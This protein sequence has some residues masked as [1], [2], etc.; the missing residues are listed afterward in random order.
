MNNLKE[1]LLKISIVISY[2]FIIIVLIIA[3]LS[4]S[5]TMAILIFT[6]LFTITY[7][8]IDRRKLYKVEKIQ[9]KIIKLENDKNNLASD[10]VGLEKNKNELNTEVK[11]LKSEINNLDKDKEENKKTLN[12]EVIDIENS[13]KDLEAKKESIKENFRK[14]ALEGYLEKLKIEYSSELKKDNEELENKSITLKNEYKNL[15]TDYENLKQEYDELNSHSYGIVPTDFQFEK[16]ETYKMKLDNIHLKEKE[17]IAR[18]NKKVKNGRKISILYDN[19]E[20]LSFLYFNM[21]CDY[22]LSKLN[23]NNYPTRIK[24][25]EKLHSTIFKVTEY[26]VDIPTQYKELKLEELETAY[27][28][29][30][31]KEREKEILREQREQEKDDLKAQKEIKEKHDKIDKEI[32]T[33]SLVKEKIEEKI[34]LAANEEIEALKLEL[35]KL[36]EKIS[37]FENEKSDLDYR[38]KNTGAGYVY[39]ISNIGSFGE[40]VYKIGVTRRLDPYQRIQEL[41]SASVP[42]KFDVHAMIF[43]YQAY[44][45]EN[46]LHK[47]FDKQRINK[48]N[49]R[50]EFFKIDIEQIK[51][52]LSSHKE[53]T[54][55]FIE[56]ARAHEYKESLMVVNE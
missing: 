11:N 34:K 55:D 15:Q 26:N 42:F 19:L 30:K 35:E 6:P 7:L 31:L 17:M 28:Y 29:Y 52:I 39:I 45:L 40:N 1:I 49:N 4:K 9:E 13:I 37:E 18:L 32:E 16:S 41:S 25:I 33:L 44:Q 51:K 20:Q 8:L 46:E 3:I 48:V 2:F 5:I 53:L 54:F 22:N 50:K 21:A 56:E 36:R 10:I 24:E 47:Y 23:F 14:E 43:S 12:E 27:S 38:L